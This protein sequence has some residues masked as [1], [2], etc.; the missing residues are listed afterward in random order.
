MM[1]ISLPMCDLLALE[2]VTDTWCAGLA[3]ALA[4]HGV[5]AFRRNRFVA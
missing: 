4:R 2:A 5:M 3:R 1:Q